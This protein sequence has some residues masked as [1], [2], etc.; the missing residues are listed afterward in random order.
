[1]LDTTECDGSDLAVLTT[2]SKCYRHAYLIQT[3]EF[4]IGELVQ[5]RA[6]AFNVN[7]WGNFSQLNIAG[8]TIQSEPAKMVSP[9]EGTATTVDQIELD[10]LAMT[11]LVET[12]NTF[13]VSSYN[14]QVYDPNAA[15]WIEVVGET[16]SFTQTTHIV[17]GL[18]MGTDYSF[19][20][21]AENVHG[22]G[23]FS[24]TVIV[25]ADDKPG[26]P[27]SVATTGNGLNVDFAWLAPSSDNGSPIT[28]YKLLIQA[29]NLDMVEETVYCAAE[30]PRLACSVPFEALTLDPYLLE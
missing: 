23:E 9:T 27:G 29:K 19:R 10:W 16:S 15:D 5:A 7:G 1:M 12:G 17:T 28:V 3:Y 18:I 13:Y 30:Q 22:F 6:R 20:L 25:R 14:L 4:V 24:D 26:T 11:T 8:A 2:T 21:R